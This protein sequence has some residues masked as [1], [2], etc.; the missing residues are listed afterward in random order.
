MGQ[1]CD[2]IV[3]GGGPAGSAAAR[4]AAL[5]GLDVLI[6]DKSP[7]PHYKPCGGALSLNRSICW[8]GPFPL[9]SWKGR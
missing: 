9:R 6:L 4:T 2:V 3:V 7:F 8:T 1:I 5:R